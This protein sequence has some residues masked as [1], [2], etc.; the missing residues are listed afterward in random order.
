MA[1]GSKS[2]PR[3]QS[4]PSEPEAVQET[5]EEHGRRVEA[6]QTKPESN[7]GLSV[8]TLVVEDS[9]ADFGYERKPQDRPLID[10]LVKHIQAS[11][12]ADGKGKSVPVNGK[13]EATKMAAL[14]RRASQEKVFADQGVGVR[15]KED[16]DENGVG[17]ILFR[18]KPKTVRKYTAT[19]VRNYFGLAADAT[20]T[21][22]QRNEYRKAHNL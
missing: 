1:L 2:K 5:D 6:A 9:D 18:A 22:E 7:G 19:D 10:A 15:L 17:R 14:I 16:V 13:K 3:F 4:V 20:V 11:W 12:D 8:E 21:T